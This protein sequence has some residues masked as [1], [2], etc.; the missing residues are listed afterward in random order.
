MT[1]LLIVI[2]DYIIGSIFTGIAGIAFSPATKSTHTLLLWLLPPAMAAAPAPLEFD[3]TARGN[4]ADHPAYDPER[5]FGFETD[6]PAKFSVRLPEGNYRVTVRLG[7]KRA[8]TH[9]SVRAEQRRLMLEDFATPRGKFIE[10]S[11][12][13]NVRTPAL[14]DL[15]A[16]APGGT[17]VK[18]KP[19]ELG[20]LNWDDK[21]TLAFLPDASAV[22]SLN[23][24]PV[25]VPVVYLA[26]DSTVTDQGVAPG[27]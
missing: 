5:G 12:V 9:T 14:G 4:L 24:E 8:A 17:S 11:F 15:P 26:G 6:A 1:R 2:D 22:N 7:A 13:V 18:L 10:R 23:I 27:A 20:A 21:L 3:L 16:N 19:R 25:D